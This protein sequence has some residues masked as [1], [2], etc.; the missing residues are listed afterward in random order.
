MGRSRRKRYS[1]EFKAEAVRL[2][3]TSDRA[4]TEIAAH[5]GVTAKSLHEWVRAMRPP[6][7]DRLTGD[8]RR[9][10][11]QLRRDNARLRMERDILKKAAAFFARETSD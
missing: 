2:V 6:A 1:A 10:L 5:L 11:E 7:P 9:E 4:I 8:E 3:Q